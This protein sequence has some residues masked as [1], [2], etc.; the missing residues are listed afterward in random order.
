MLLGE[1]QRAGC[2]GIRRR[3]LATGMGQLNGRRCAMFSHDAHH[4]SKGIDLTVMPDAQVLGRDA[5]ARLH[6][7]GLDDDQ[8]GAANGAAAVVHQVPVGGLAILG[9][10][11]ILAHGRDPEPVAG[12]DAAQP[13]R[14]EQSGL[15]W[16]HGVR[17]RL[18]SSFM[19]YLLT[20]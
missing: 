17:V 2:D 1:G 4:G 6:R 8:A 15:R 20:G 19:S 3:C 12:S 10:D 14:R 11:R 16:V 13:D 9:E 18:V 5:A 7:R